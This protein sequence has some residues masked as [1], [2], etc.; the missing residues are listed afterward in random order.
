MRGIDL[1]EYNPVT[2]LQKAALKNQVIVLKATEGT[3]WV[4]PRFHQRWEELKKVRV[5]VRGAYHFADPKTDPVAQANH[6]VDTVQPTIYD[7]LILDIETDGG[8]GTAKWAAR[9]R[10][11]VHRRTV[12]PRRPLGK[13]TWTYSFS[14]YFAEFLPWL[15]AHGIRNW[16]AAYGSKPTGRY[17][18]H[19]Y[20]DKGR[21][22]GVTGNVDSSFWSR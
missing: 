7:R 4:D 18:A 6:F 1:S 9:F 13:F 10:R 16:K 15:S 2:S 20:T 11:Q 12:S 8:P 22:A 21:S 19:Q 17:A 5:K 3:S 14:A